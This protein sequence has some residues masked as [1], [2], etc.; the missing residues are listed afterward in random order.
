MVSRLHG[1][2]EANGWAS[3]ASSRCPPEPPRAGVRGGLHTQHPAWLTRM[4]EQF[5]KK[6]KKNH[7]SNKYI[8]RKAL[9]QTG[10]WGWTEGW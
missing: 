2:E 9:F 4:P 5:V 7:S 1:S 3:W 6:V 10:S 8:L